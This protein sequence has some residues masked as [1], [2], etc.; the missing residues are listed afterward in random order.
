MKKLSICLLLAVMAFT[1]GCDKVSEKVDEIKTEVTAQDRQYGQSETYELTETMK[2][3]F[4]DLKIEKAEIVDEVDGYVADDPETHFL[5]IDVK[6]DNTFAD[7]ASIPMSYS[8]FELTWEGLDG[9]VIY[10]E[11]VFAEGQLP[12]EYEIFK[13][14]SRSGKLIYMVPSSAKNFSFIYLEIWDDDFEGN[15]YTINFAL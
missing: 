11:E 8:D 6:I 4:F 7:T 9:N 2:T 3:A 10:S 12:D 1:S 15:D 13:G 5:V 14:D